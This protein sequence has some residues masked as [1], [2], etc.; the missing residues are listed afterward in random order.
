MSHDCYA[1]LMTL[2]EMLAL[3][4]LYMIVCDTGKGNES[5]PATII[6][7]ILAKEIFKVFC[8]QQLNQ[9]VA[10]ASRHIVIFFCFFKKVEDIDHLT[11]VQ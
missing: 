7:E 11:P 10:F 5:D 4:D 2:G 8:F 6:C 9:N 3:I 1:S